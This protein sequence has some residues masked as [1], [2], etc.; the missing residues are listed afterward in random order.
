MSASP[1]PTPSRKRPSSCTA[2]VAAA[3][4]PRVMVVRYPQRLEAGLPG[5]ARLLDEF[6]RA[7]AG[8]CS[9]HDR[10]YP[11]PGITP[12]GGNMSDPGRT[13]TRRIA[14]RAAPGPTIS[15][16]YCQDTRASPLP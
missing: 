14:V 12:P 8:P 5:H 10:K 13:G 1:V 6:R 3:F 2:L 16:H 7:V 11:K 15:V 9:S 4:V